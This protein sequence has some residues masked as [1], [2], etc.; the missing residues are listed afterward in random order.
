ML[1]GVFFCWIPACRSNLELLRLCTQIESSSRHDVIKKKTIKF[2]FMNFVVIRYVKVA[3]SSIPVIL[4]F[5]ILPQLSHG[6]YY[7]SITNHLADNCRRNGYKI[8]TLT[9]NLGDSFLDMCTVGNWYLSAD[10]QVYLVSYF[11]IYYLAAKPRLGFALALIQ[12][13]FFSVVSIL[14]TKYYDIS[15]YFNALDLQM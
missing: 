10:F 6:P 2:N 7:S 14:Y 3:I 9:T 4:L 8:F 5:F 15:A 13:V 12:C 11:V 1:F